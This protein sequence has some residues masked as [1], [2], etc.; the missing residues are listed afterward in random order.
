M[1]WLIGL[2]ILSLV[3]GG[4]AFWVST[5]GYPRTT[6]QA[7]V[8]DRASAVHAA[9]AKT[10]ALAGTGLLAGDPE[11]DAA[12]REVTIRTANLETSTQLLADI[13]AN[14]ALWKTLAMAGGGA[15]IVLLAAGLLLRTR[16]KQPV[17]R[18]A[19]V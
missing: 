16:R 11:Y 9:V 4:I 18:G 8:D 3:F 19:T 14:K 13:D 10:K 6:A 12:A 17:L 2:G 7:L 15:G 1:K 5:A